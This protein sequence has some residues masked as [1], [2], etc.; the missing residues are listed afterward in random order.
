M[1]PKTHSYEEG[2]YYSHKLEKLKFIGEKVPSAGPG[3]KLL[4][5]QFLLG[6]NLLMHA[7]TPCSQ[8]PFVRPSVRSSIGSRSVGHS[9]L[10]SQSLFV[11]RLL[12][13]RTCVTLRLPSVAP[14]GL[15]PPKLSNSQVLQVCLFTINQTTRLQS[16]LI[17]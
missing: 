13:P 17:L 14:G 2:V 9:L 16:A 10:P 12:S 11:S 6:L 3:L 15:V 8:L 1:A 4:L 7:L 5:C